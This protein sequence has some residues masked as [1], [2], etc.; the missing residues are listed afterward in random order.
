[1]AHHRNSP[2]G[3][4]QTLFEKGNVLK[5]KAGNQRNRKYHNNYV[6]LGVQQ[7]PFFL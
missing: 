7:N 3:E 6:L 1:M 2:Q 4:F 5:I